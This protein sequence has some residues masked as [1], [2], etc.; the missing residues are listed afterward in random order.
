MTK[1]SEQFLR[2]RKLLTVAPL[3]IAPFLTMLFWSLG[4]GKGIGA[5]ASTHTKGLNTEI[6]N[7]QI[8][9]NSSA[10]DKYALYE[11]AKRDSLRK[12]EAERTDPYF[13]LKTIT[14]VNRK[15]SM[16][17]INSSLGK[18]DFREG[19]DE[20]AINRKIAEINAAI[21]SPVKT[22]GSANPTANQSQEDTPSDE[23]IDRLEQMMLMMQSEGQADPE[24]QGVESVLDK[25]LDVQHPER[26]RQRIEQQSIKHQGKVFTVSKLL[27][28]NVV[29]AFGNRMSKDTTIETAGFID[30]NSPSDNFDN[31]NLIKA[32]VHIDH[33]LSAGSVVKLE[34]AD[35][36]Y[37]NGNKINPGTFLFGVCSIQNER[38]QINVQSILF[39]QSLIP[40]SLVV[41]DFDGLE[42]IYVP[43]STVNEATRQGYD[44]LLQ[45]VQLMSLDP[46]VG[47]QAA[48][49]G[50]QTAKTLFSRKNRVV[51]IQIKSGYQVFLKDTSKNTKTF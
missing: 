40:V 37:I 44:Q 6:P 12:A 1:H 33:V 43:R 35:E 49:A 45:G 22:Q 9:D 16:G 42:G 13:R 26:V 19:D 29:N 32:L 48:S 11:K 50:I 3:L 31:A 17:S 47:A 46:S 51:R 7:A 30:L 27:G 36:V 41:H 20:L 39:K 4:G 34:L 5:A 28:E 15:D 21:S 24:M 23:S 2:Q 18:K 8:K 10:W 25:I 38:L 14:E